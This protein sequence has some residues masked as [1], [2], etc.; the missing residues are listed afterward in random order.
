MISRI[1]PPYKGEVRHV[2]SARRPLP[3]YLVL[4]VAIFLNLGHASIC[5]A[6]HFFP[7][8]LTIS[9]ALVTGV[10]GPVRLRESP[11]PFVYV[12][13]GSLRSI[14]ST[15]IIDA[16]SRYP[17]VEAIST[18]GAISKPVIR[19][20][21]YNRVVTVVDGVRQEGQQWGD[22]HGVEVDSD[23]IGSV[24]ILK[25]PASLMYGSDALGGALIMRSV[26]EPSPGEG[27]VE[28]TNQFQ[29]VNGL[30]GTSVFLCGNDPRSLVY[31]AR[32]SGKAAH[33]YSNPVDGFV[34]NSQF[35]ERSASGMFGLHRSWGQSH[36]RLSYWHQ[37]PSLPEI[38]EDKEPEGK[39]S[40]YLH[41]IPY[42]QIRHVKASLD[43]TLYVG[44]GS[45]KGV[46]SYQ[47]NSREEFEDEPGVSLSLGT[48]GYDVRYL[49][50]SLG[51]WKLTAGLGGMLQSSRNRS[52]EVLIPD[53]GLWDIGV[54]G[55]FNRTF[56]SVDLSGGVRFDS[57][58][59][60]SRKTGDD[61][62]PFKRNFS[63]FSGS[64][65]IVW[66]P[67]PSVDLRANIARGFR[68]PNMS[69]LGS[70]GE[71]EGTFRFEI[72]NALLK[73]EKSNQLDLG[74]SWTRPWISMSLS[75]FGSIV[76]DFIYLHATGGL[77]EENTPVYSYA[78]RTAHFLGGEVAID[79]HPLE[80]IHIGST[81]SV[82]EGMFTGGETSPGMKYVPMIPAPK[83]VLE[84]GYEGGSFRAS[85]R[86]DHYFPKN[87]VFS[88]YGTETATPSYTL[89]GASV[90]KDFT[91]GKGTKMT[92][93]IFCENI[94][95]ASYQNHLSRLKY[96]GFN[97]ATRKAGYFGPGR[98]I[99]VKVYIPISYG[100]R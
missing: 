90:G 5:H 2:V 65:G 51:G 59:L 92:V 54:Y 7:D 76:Y 8:T 15:N 12:S 79:V 6:Q 25:G 38:E 49:S 28:F 40:T 17:G 36:L 46:L 10:G 34:P 99:G 94:L 41:G 20:M 61:M 42:Q 24:D 1:I 63:A 22:E 26:P 95:N 71:H 68:A 60:D 57:R 73:P 77:S 48:V 56:E 69:E 11:I 88:A 39:K 43:G 78:G 83:W 50:P 84:V 80:Q 21:S 85:A 64:V 9:E 98:N 52:Q 14:A 19:G 18:G 30:V 86:M 47:N 31:S 3:L 44:E 66:H 32:I 74:V 75:A 96:A 35:S 70:H 87:H 37:T 23:A 33:S 4:C 53:Y 16:L 93:S 72:G 62:D 27:R 55:T 13:E 82:T 67:V 58:M 97:P 100:L 45:L 91:L 89:I 29:S 81:F